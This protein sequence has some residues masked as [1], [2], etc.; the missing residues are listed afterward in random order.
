MALSASPKNIAIAFAIGILT[1]VVGIAVYE[2][3]ALSESSDPLA[4]S[5]ASAA[6]TAAG[7]LPSVTVYQSPTCGC[8]NEW[9]DH[10]RDNGFAVKTTDMQDVRPMKNRLGVPKMLSSCHTAVVGG[11]VVEGHVPATDIK[12]LLRQ[13]PDVTGLSVPGM[14]VGSPGME[15]GDRVDPYRVVAFSEKTGKTSVFN[16]YSGR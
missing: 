16:T 10:L 14:P 7:E 1:A 9:V 13:Q 6:H 11:Y 12:R 15:Q 2:S 4:A 3:G 5:K 8:C